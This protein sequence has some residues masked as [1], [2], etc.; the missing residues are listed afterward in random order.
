MYIG[1]GCSGRR[2]CGWL[3][4]PSLLCGPTLQPWPLSWRLLIFGFQ[5]WPD[6]TN[7]GSSISNSDVNVNNLTVIIVQKSFNKVFEWAHC[8][9]FLTLVFLVGLWTGHWK[10]SLLAWWLSPPLSLQKIIFM[11]L[12]I[13]IIKWHRNFLKIFYVSYIATAC[14]MTL[15]V[16]L[17]FV[18]GL[19]TVE[20][21]FLS[22]LASVFDLSLSAEGGLS[23]LI[24]SLSP[25]VW[26]TT[27]SESL[28]ITP[29]LFSSLLL[30]LE[31]LSS[32]DL[33]L[34][35]R[36]SSLSLSLLLLFSLSVFFFLE[37]PINSEIMVDVK[38]NMIFPCIYETLHTDQRLRETRFYSPEFSLFF[39]LTFSIHLSTIS[40]DIVF[41][42]M[43][44]TNNAF[45][46]FKCKWNQHA[47]K[48]IIFEKII[49]FL[50]NKAR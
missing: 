40:A 46:W 12:K 42:A 35:F 44:S 1:R 48:R 25:F 9:Y 32:L 49:A 15:P 28:L 24:W 4:W 16:D 26:V 50:V 31:C 17:N 27:P 18:L 38:L 29:S 22:G 30:C 8:R 45:S 43:K 7:T 39:P 10:A 19:F 23:I 14:Q 33:S 21:R 2:L 3:L 34:F 6:D 47:P 20:A 37:S 11:N 36:F 5:F 41:T 13:I